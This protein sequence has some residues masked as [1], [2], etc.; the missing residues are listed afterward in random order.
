MAAG[1]SASQR[2]RFHGRTYF[3]FQRNRHRLLAADI[4]CIALLFFM[5]LFTSTF[6]VFTQDVAIVFQL[7]AIAPAAFIALSVVWKGMVP[8]I[9]CFLGIVLM[10]NS[11]ILPYFEP[12]PIEY[13]IPGIDRVFTWTYYTPESVD[14]GSS[15]NF[16]LGF[17]M[18]AFSIIIAYR[19]SM[20]FTKNRPE[21]LDDEW[22]KYPM[23]QD[24]T[25]LAGGSTERS[26]PVKSLM[27]DQD[28]Y[29]L[30]RY[31]Y[32]LTVVNGT[33]HLVRPNGMV[34][35]DSAIVRDRESGRVIG[36]PRYTGYFM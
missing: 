22:S 33:P 13:T 7:A 27:T 26:V 5:H 25:L 11:V 1:H 12:E 21:S 9:I 10:H 24:N 8:L 19:P 29:L 32:V 6:Q 28:R 16:F 2:S 17:G 36:R 4:V 15:M 30:W 18:A 14:V 31:E 20:L 35:A 23:W 3:W 34:P